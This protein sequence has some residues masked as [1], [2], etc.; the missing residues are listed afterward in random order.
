MEIKKLK[1]YYAHTMLSYNST[2][3]LEDIK[4][5]NDLGFE[6][7]N[8]NT[9]E[10]QEKVNDFVLLHGKN[11]VMSFFDEIIS[12]CDLLAFR[13]LPDGKILSGISSE[14]TSAKN[15]NKPIIELPCSLISRM[16]DYSETK[17]F[18]IEIG[19]YKLN[20]KQND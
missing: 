4:L 10:I 18:L 3:E 14:I 17:Q 9:P 20:T 7:I 6:V 19:H 8:P 15:Y 2:Q 5:L 11:K 16:L 1:C 12:K 13:A